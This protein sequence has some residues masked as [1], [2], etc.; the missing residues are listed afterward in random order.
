MQT[1][2]HKWQQQYHTDIEKMGIEELMQELTRVVKLQEGREGGSQQ[3]HKTLYYKEAIRDKVLVEVELLLISS[4]KTIEEA[5]R[6]CH[7]VAFELRP[8]RTVLRAVSNGAE[9]RSTQIPR[10]YPIMLRA[11]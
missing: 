6:R 2:Y 11:T 4:R 7:E 8:R 10:L 9:R 5:E 1:K 3:Y